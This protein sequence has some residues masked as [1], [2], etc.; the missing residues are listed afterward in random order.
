MVRHQG[1][2]AGALIYLIEV[3]QRAACKEL[4]FAALGRDRGALRHMRM[5][6]R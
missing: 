3:H 6:E 5:R 1:V 4:V 2:N